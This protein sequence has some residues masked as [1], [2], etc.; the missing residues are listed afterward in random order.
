M[1]WDSSSSRRGRTTRGGSISVCASWRWMLLDKDLDLE[2]VVPPL[3]KLR[4]RLAK[5]SVLLKPPTE[6]LS[7]ESGKFRRRT[8]QLYLPEGIYPLYHTMVEDCK[9]C[10][11][12]KPSPPRARFSGVRA[13]NFGDVV[14]MDHRETKR[15]SKK[16]QLYL[17]LAAATTSPLWGA[18]QDEVTGPRLTTCSGRGRVSIH[19]SQGIVNTDIPRVLVWQDSR[20]SL[21]LHTLPSSRQE[22]NIA[23][24]DD[25]EGLWT[26]VGSRR[27]EC[28][29]SPWASA[30]CPSAKLKMLA[31]G[32]ILMFASFHS[33]TSCASKIIVVSST[34]VSK[35]SWA[36]VRQL[37]T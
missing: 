1:Y 30:C 27:A 10:Q 9:V 15:T 29:T 20:S 21:F 16:H 37:S 32:R 34:D 7:H 36:S 3:T 8:S 25:G 4:W 6:A 19:A 31:S 13:K 35:A 11:K 22:G 17:V 33:I 23:L 28:C 12:T 26:M 5:R 2:R 18:T 24:I 14:F